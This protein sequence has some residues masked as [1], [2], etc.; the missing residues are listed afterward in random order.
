MTL[1]KLNNRLV[2]KFEKYPMFSD[3]LNEVYENFLTPDAKQYTLPGVNIKEEDEK[4]V[5]SFAAPGLSKEDFKISIE[6][7]VLTVSAEK[8]EEVTEE[9]PL[10]SR[11]EFSYSNF[12]RSFNLPETVN[13]ADVNAT[14]E[15]GILILNI[16]KKTVVK[17][18]PVLEVKVS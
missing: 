5:L 14:Y 1:L 6:E 8:K 3:L 17:Q 11:K 18:K 4:F 12:K 7:N 2:N 9:K 15:N 16:P 13:V 10:F